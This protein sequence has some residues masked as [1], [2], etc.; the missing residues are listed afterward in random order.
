[1]NPN[2]IIHVATIALAPIILTTELVRNTK[3]LVVTKIDEA[4]CELH[5]RRYFDKKHDFVRRSKR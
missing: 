4:K 3:K 5:N 2:T 1:M